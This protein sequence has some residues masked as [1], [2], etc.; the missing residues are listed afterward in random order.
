MSQCWRHMVDLVRFLSDRTTAMYAVRICA[1]SVVMQQNM[2]GEEGQ[3]HTHW[4][5]ECKK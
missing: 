5:S 2:A 1:S 4:C 3:V